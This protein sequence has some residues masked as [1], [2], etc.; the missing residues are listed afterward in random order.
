[1]STPILRIE[2]D[3][4][5]QHLFRQPKSGNIGAHQ[6]ARLVLFLENR[7]LIAER[8]QIIGYGQGGGTGAD[9]GDAFAVF[10][11]RNLRQQV[12][13]FSAQ[14]GGDAL[15]TADRN[16]LAIQA[17]SPAGRLARAVAGAAQDRRKHIRFPIQ[18][19][20]VG[21]SALRDEADV[22]GNIGVRGACPL[23]INDFVEIVRV[24][25]VSGFHASPIDA[26]TGC[27]A[28][29]LGSNYTC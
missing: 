27:Q 16:R 25:N 26:A 15:Q 18:H 29:L 24:L 3:L 9:A 12:V 22:L 19:V 23:A 4:F 6:A 21:I 17:A 2:L 28:C 1:M 5:R 10:L 13:D 8:H 7:D 14:I 20:G 11:G